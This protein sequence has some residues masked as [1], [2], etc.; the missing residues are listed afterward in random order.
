MAQRRGTGTFAVT[1]ASLADMATFEPSARYLLEGLDEPALIVQEQTVRVA[2]G[3]AKSLLGDVEGS[4]IRLAIRHPEALA[5]V[6][7]GRSGDIDF[8]GIGSVGR[9]WRLAVR[10]LGSRTLLLRLIDSTAA[11]AAEKMRT[12]FVANA[13][14]E[15]RTPLTAVIGYAE[16]LEEADLDPALAA[17]FAGTIQTEA[18][19]MLRI[20]EDLMSLSRIEA[21]RFIT[22]ADQVS[23]ESLISSALA[24]V[25]ATA[26]NLGCRILVDVQEELPPVAGD[27]PQ[28]VQV[29]DNLLGNALRY[30]CGSTDCT[31][32]IAA[33]SDG[34]FVKIDVSD[35]G[36][37]IAREHLPFLTRRFYRVDEARSRASGGT[38]LGLAIVKHIVERHR[39]TLAIDSAPGEGTTVRVRLPIA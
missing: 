11:H 29:I 23:I 3:L 22:P 27:F 36:P 6:L 21:D 5:F 10:N 32:R 30:A 15:L 35:N 1:S 13:S 14:H 37:G 26:G 33:T 18:R 9:P 31:I 7:D 24:T 2:N 28:L 8:T 39:G 34:D 19:R 12:D 16:S 4:D 25:Q 17:K 38:G 20:I